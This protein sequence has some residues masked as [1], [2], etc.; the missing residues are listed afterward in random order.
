[1]TAV[2][3][4]AL[5]DSEKI[6]LLALADCA[7]DEGHCWP[8]MAS[9]VRKCSKTDR[10]IQTAIKSL[11]DAGH[12][13]RREVPGKGCNYTVHPRSDFTPEAAS[14]RNGCA[15]PPKPVRGTPEAA[16]G[17]PSKNHHEPSDDS[18]SV[19]APS[20]RPEHVQ[21]FWNEIA[22]K[23]CRPAIRDL[24]P[25][26]RQL[27]KARIAQ[28]SLDDFKTVFAKCSRSA[29]LRGDNGRTPLT[30]D[31]IMK[32]GNFQKTLEGNYDQ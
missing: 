7:N 28:Y 12:L 14:P 2:W 21:E 9:L 23:L 17:K 10:T 1:M 15:T 11:C 3:A 18:A 20:L 25:E 8:G 24:T 32:K 30:F 16:S 13:T 27:V 6:V 5:P 26:R 19:D 4:L 29:F 31:W 22:P